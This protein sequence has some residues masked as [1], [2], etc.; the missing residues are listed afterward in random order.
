MHALSISTI[1]GHERQMAVLPIPIDGEREDRLVRQDDDAL[2]T[3]V[4]ITHDDPA[5][6]CRLDVQL[7]WKRSR[8][9]SRLSDARTLIVKEQIGDTAR[10]HVGEHSGK[11]N[12]SRESA[13][14]LFVP[15]HARA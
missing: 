1:D 5:A 12:S 10:L 13:H 14:G 8:A 6:R 15:C 4:M 9:S 3:P 2:L 7:R 11:H